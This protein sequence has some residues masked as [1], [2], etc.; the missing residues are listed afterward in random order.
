MDL[1]IK[2]AAGG[3]FLEVAAGAEA[4]TA[5]FLN[6]L[7][8]AIAD[9][10]AKRQYRYVRILLIVT[11][12]RADLS[13]TETYQAWQRASQRGISHTQIAY[14]MDGRPLSALARFVEAIARNRRILL[15][16][17]EHRDAALEWLNVSSSGNGR[18]A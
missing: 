8:D 16:F 2:A 18:V 5:A 10:L 4:V 3:E 1:K 6:E 12:P 14:V 9:Y 11:A 7:I 15:R 13:I 17:F